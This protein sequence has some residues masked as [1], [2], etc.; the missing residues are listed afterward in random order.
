[1]VK[2]PRSTALTDVLARPSILL[3]TLGNASDVTTAPAMLAE[4]TGRIRRLS[5]DEGYDADWL[6][7]DLRN[8]GVVPVIPGKRGRKRR[9][10]H[11]R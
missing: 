8:S 6:R 9:I 2:T 4:A 1:M 10:R 11:D 3:L 7:T 5:A